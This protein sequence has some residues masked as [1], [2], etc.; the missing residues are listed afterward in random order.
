MLIWDPDT[1]N[2]MISEFEKNG[3]QVHV[4]AIGDRGVRSTLDA[5]EHA[6][7]VN[8][9]GDRRHMISHVQL[10]HPHDVSRF[11]DLNVIASFQALWAYPDQ[12][13]KKLTFPVLGPIRSNWNYPMNSINSLGGRI[14]GGSD[15]TVS[16][17]NPL[18][19]MEVAVTRR[20]LGS[21]HGEVLILEEAV[22]LETILNSYT[23]EA[24]YG[25]F[26][27]DKIGSIE[28]GKLADVVVLNRN[29][30]EIPKHQ[31]HETLVE[32]TIF[33]GRIIHENYLLD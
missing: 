3:F 9:I 16:S 25:I 31:I 4:H 26:L 12:Y 11:K 33:N 29:L 10:V 2:E 1:L 22:S 13:M 7:A 32:I 27:D 23:K 21:E 8:G 5:F 14:V 17:L 20:E 28:I 19:A 30:F 15:W 6:R 24:A 18:H